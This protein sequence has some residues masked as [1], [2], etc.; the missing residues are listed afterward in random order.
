MV[1]FF[2]DANFLPYSFFFLILLDQYLSTVLPNPTAFARA[3]N[4][5]EGALFYHPKKRRGGGRERETGRIAE[6][7]KRAI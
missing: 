6:P 5:Y 7:D 4:I 2:Q 1:G 3:H